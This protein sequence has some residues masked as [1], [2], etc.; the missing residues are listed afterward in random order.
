MMSVEFLREFGFPTAFLVAILAGLYRL[1]N[2]FLTFLGERLF[3]DP[4]GLITRASREHFELVDTV[5]R[6]SDVQRESLERIEEMFREQNK[7]LDEVLSRA[8]QRE[9]S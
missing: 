6:N 2:R 7:K 3:G 5:R 8:S 9:E 1:G 4:N